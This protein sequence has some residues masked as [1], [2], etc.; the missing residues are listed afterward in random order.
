MLSRR[1][2]QRKSRRRQFRHAA[3]LS[4]ANDV[5]PIRCVLWD[6]SDGG[7]R[8]TAGIRTRELPDRFTLIMAAGAVRRP[9][10]TVW[11]NGQFVGVKF[12]G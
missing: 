9:C 6:I 4:I 1:E 5:P 3:L 2:D 10:E 7:A 8:L 12:L 11:R